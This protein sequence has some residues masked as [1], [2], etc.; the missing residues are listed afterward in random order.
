ME[1]YQIIGTIVISLFALIY[2]VGLM[3]KSN[4]D[5]KKEMLDMLRNGSEISNETYIK[6]LKEI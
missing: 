1:T 6:Y 5:G 2:I 4:R 3:F